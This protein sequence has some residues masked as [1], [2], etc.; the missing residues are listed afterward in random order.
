MSTI[1]VSIL[2]SVLWALDDLG[3]RLYNRKTGEVR[4]AGS[5]VGTVLPL[6]LGAIG[7]YGLFQGSQF[8]DALFSLAG[9]CAVLYPPYVLFALSHRSFVRRHFDALLGR[10]PSRTVETKLS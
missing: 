7:V 10:L 4:T 1:L 6:V 2:L 5:S 3:I 8:E 9:I